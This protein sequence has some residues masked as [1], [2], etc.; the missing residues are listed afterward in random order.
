MEKDRFYHLSSYKHQSDGD[1]DADGGST[2]VHMQV[3]TS[4]D[5]M[6]K[7]FLHP[8]RPNLSPQR[9]AKGQRSQGLSALL[10]HAPH[11]PRPYVHPSA[12]ARWPGLARSVTVSS[13]SVHARMPAHR[14]AARARSLQPIHRPRAVRRPA[15]AQSMRAAVVRPLLLPRTIRPVPGIA[16]RG[17][18]FIAFSD[19]P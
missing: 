3:Y 12:G 6:H 5:S 18:L 4:R 1:A 16:C 7:L 17:C 8:A 13:I 15:T 14:V 19:F 11:L 2:S 10:A 9:N